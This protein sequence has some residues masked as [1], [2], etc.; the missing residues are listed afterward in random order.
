MVMNVNVWTDLFLAGLTAAMIIR[1]RWIKQFPEGRKALA[2]V[3]GVERLLM[4]LYFIGLVILPLAYIL[5]PWLNFAD[6]PLPGWVRAIGAVTFIGGIWLL[7]QSHQALAANWT[8]GTEVREGN[9]LVTT[10]TFSRIRHP[11]YAAHWLMAVGQVLLLAN[12][13]AGPGSLLAF[14]LLYL[15]RVPREEAMLL[16][17]FGDRY[18]DYMRRTGR[19]VPRFAGRAGR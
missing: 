13:L 9:T 8:G 6:F 12:W 10:G 18:R 11:M 2:R 7:D 16:Q 19:V 17:R 4:L 1:N 3:G 14:A 5:T 15:V